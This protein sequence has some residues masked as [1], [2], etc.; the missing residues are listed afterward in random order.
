M[1][2]FVLHGNARSVEVTVPEEDYIKVYSYNTLEETH[3]AYFL[4]HCDYEKLASFTSV[5]ALL[6]YAKENCVFKD[7]PKPLCP[8]P[9]ETSPLDEVG[10]GIPA[11]HMLLSESVPVNGSAVP[12][13]LE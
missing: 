8:C 6:R 9:P 13:N 7:Y 10:G 12:L 4:A 11:R 3:L 1:K 2:S 5:S